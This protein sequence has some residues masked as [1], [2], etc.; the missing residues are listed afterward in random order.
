MKI[1]IDF[2][3]TLVNTAELSKRFLDIYKPGN[4]LA[5]YHDLPLEESLAFFKKYYLEITYNLELLDGVKEAFAYF[6]KNNIKTVL[7]TARG[8]NGLTNII[9]PTKEFLHKNGIV[10]DKM[11]FETGI[12]GEA[13]LNNN[14][15]LFIDDLENNIKEVNGKGVKVLLFGRKSTKFAYALNW[16]EVIRYLEKGEICEL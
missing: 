6:K 8:G 12:K 15:D 7:I 1:G 9:E 16:H 14:V 4:N 2:D 11:I 5:S 13:C 3:N 10:F